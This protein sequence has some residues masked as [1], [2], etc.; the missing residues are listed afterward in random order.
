MP[1]DLKE[2]AEPLTHLL[3]AFTW[4]VLFIG[5][6]IPGIFPELVRMHLLPEA[7]GWD[8]CW[9]TEQSLTNHIP[10]ANF[11]SLSC[12]F[13]DLIPP[14]TTSS[15]GGPASVNLFRWSPPAVSWNA[16][17]AKHSF[18]AV[19][20]PCRRGHCLLV[21]PQA[22][23]PCRSRGTG[24]T[25]VFTAFKLMFSSYCLA[26]TACWHLSSGRLN[27]TESLSF[28]C[29]CPNQHSPGFPQSWPRV[30]GAGSLAPTGAEA[31]T[32]VFL[33]ITRRTGGQDSPWI[34]QRMV[35][36]PTTPTKALLFLHGCLI[37]CCKV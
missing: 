31:H 27:S 13:S 14:P 24:K 25:I 11:H 19:L 1:S 23:L 9:S 22:A 8:S 29:F 7:H 20:C 33:P 12:F 28:M 2:E 37:C 4:G 6:T 3:S 26:P 18:T 30:T 5:L 34:P 36:D 17:E 32:K 10:L 16:R 35:L 15:P 21:L